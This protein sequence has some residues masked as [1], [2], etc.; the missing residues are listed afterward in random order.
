MLLNKINGFI[1]PKYRLLLLQHIFYNNVFFAKKKNQL[2][3]TITKILSYASSLGRF[4]C[5][6][7]SSNVDK[8][9]FNLLTFW[10]RNFIFFF[11]FEFVT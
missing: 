9:L 4:F 1:S 11:V 6:N 7:N 2:M 8:F 3:P 5:F 10:F